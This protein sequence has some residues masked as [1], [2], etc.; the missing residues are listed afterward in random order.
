MTADLHCHTT[1]SDGSDSPLFVMKLAQ[2]MGL[3]TLAITDHD[4]YAGA[5]GADRMGQSCGIRVINGVE[6]SCRDVVRGNKV[7]LL[8]YNPK[9]PE[10]LEPVLQKARQARTEAVGEMIAKVSRRYPITEEM[11]MDGVGEGGCCFK[12]HIMLAL[13]KA[14]YTREIFG[15]LFH[16]L[17]S[18]RGGSCFVPIIHNDMMDTMRYLKESGGVIVLAH[19]SVYGSIASLG[20]LLEAGIHGVELHHPRNK[21]QDIALLQRTAAERGL[22]TTGGTDFHGCFSEADRLLPLGSYGADETE[23]AALLA[24]SEAL[25]H[26]N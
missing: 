17:F 20:D 21:P 16:E 3:S 2:R 19:P 23:V 12:Q 5:Y 6:C 15:P 4:Y 7:H 11:V 26:R 13:M 8:C 18:S 10:A 14:G 24:T 22:L 25:W 9:Y 1:V